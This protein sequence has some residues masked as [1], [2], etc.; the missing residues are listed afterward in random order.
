MQSF[1][2][3]TR[4]YKTVDFDDTQSSNSWTFVAV[5]FV[6]SVLVI[7]VIVW[8]IARKN[9]CYYMNQIIGK[10]LANTH[11]L[12]KVN[13]KQSP[14]SGEEIEMSAL[15]E[16]RN[17][18]NDSEGQQNSFRRTDAMLAWAQCQK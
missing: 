1:L 13:V 7:I 11:D 3:E 18:N 6:A 10:R 5:I 2:R 12:E 14:S 4:A 15:L 17:V 16:E 9:K 8:L